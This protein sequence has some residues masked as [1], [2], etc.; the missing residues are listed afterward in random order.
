MYSQFVN[1]I[2]EWYLQN[3]RDLPW[4]NTSDPYLIWLSEIILQ[5][6]RVNQGLPY[7]QAFSQKYPSVVDFAN[8]P[9]DDILRLW[10]GLGYYSRAR[11][12]HNTAVFIVNNFNGI[13]PS[14]YESLIKLKGIGP[15]TA[16]AISSFASNEKQAVIDGNVYRVLS[17]VFNIEEDISSTQGIKFFKNFATEIIQYSKRNDIYNQAIMEFGAIQCKPQ[18]PNCIECPLIE[19][20]EAYKLKKTSLLPIK[21]GKTKITNRQINYLVKVSD[22]KVYLK[23]RNEKDIWAG[24]YDFIEIDENNIPKNVTKLSKSYNHKLSHQNLEINFYLSKSDLN[25]KIDLGK[26]Y[27]LT[28]IENLPKPIIIKKFLESDDFNKLITL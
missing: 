23:R 17:R 24:L 10:Q 28:E 1:I 21:L 11:N 9:I 20:C 3:K 16:A 8:A 26:F 25:E 27:S 19:F 5:Q 22:K 14:N 4:R 12:M 13:F 15:Y 18:S 2:I 6:T 7:Y